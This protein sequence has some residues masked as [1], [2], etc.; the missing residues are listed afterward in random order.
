MKSPHCAQGLDRAIVIGGSMAGLLAARVLADHYKEITVLER[1]EFP[2]VGAQRRGI[3]QGRHTHGLLASGRALVERL[4][5]GISKELTK[6]GALTGDIVRDMRW[7]IEGASLARFASG[8]DGLLLTR[9]LL[10]GTVRRRLLALPNVEVHE[11]FQV[12]GLAATDDGRQ[13][14]G[15]KGQG[16]ELLADLII[17]A[18]GRS[19]RAP[20]W[21][22]AIGC[23]GPAEERVQV[24][25]AYTTRFFRRDPDKHLNGDLGAVIPPTPEGKRGGVMLAQEGDRWIVTLIG[26]FGHAAPPDLDG[27]VDYARTLPAPYILDVLRD[28]EPLGEPASGRFPA[29]VRRRYEKLRR[30]PGGFLV[31][32]DAISSFNP[33]YGQGMSVAALEAIELSAALKNGTSDLARRFFCRASRVVDAAWSVIVGNDFRMPETIG[34]RSASVKVSNWYMSRLQ[35]TARWDPVTAMAFFRV[36]NLLEP[37]SGVM[38]PRVVLHV[39]K[40]NLARHGTAQDSSEARAEQPAL[41]VE[42]LK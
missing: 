7:F 38:R 35:K 11:K 2:P 33:R 28:A 30:F 41:K 3:P 22:E 20:Q 9:P 14:R 10:E 6:A 21:L 31:C 40:G 29:S 1:D 27:F 15:V 24:D 16:A 25:L 5:P 13:I 34:P 8:L 42:P 12:D 17:D 36:A 4:F 18:T 39:V 23:P 19:S 32:G 26:H 37:P